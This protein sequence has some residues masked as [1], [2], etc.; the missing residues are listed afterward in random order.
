M[1]NRYY[2]PGSKP[3]IL[4]H[5]NLKITGTLENGL[6]HVFDDLMHLNGINHAD[7]DPMTATLKIAYDAS[8]QDIEKI[9]HILK[10]YNCDFAATIW[11]RL[12]LGWY[13]FTDENIRDS[14]LHSARCIDYNRYL[15]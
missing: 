12:K 5:R 2:R 3:A 15:H 4:A 9:H 6:T 1:K 11:N 14:L 10:A 13:H 7:F 8:L